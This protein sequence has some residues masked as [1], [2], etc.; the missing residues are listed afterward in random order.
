MVPN[1]QLS[2]PQ[3]AASWATLSQNQRKIETLAIP[4]PLRVRA[5]DL[6][7]CVPRQKVGGACPED[8]GRILP[9]DKVLGP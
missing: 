7:R 1:F 3:A 5:R 2:D 8:G 4:M 9:L 6:H